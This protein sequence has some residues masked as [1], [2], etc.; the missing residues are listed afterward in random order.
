MTYRRHNATV[1]SQLRK[2][3]M[4]EFERRLY[5]HWGVYIGNQDIVHLTG[6]GD[7]ISGQF[8]S[9]HV[10]TISG[11]RFNKA[12]AVKDNFWAVA[13]DSIATQNN[14]LDRTR[15]PYSPN[16]IAKRASSMLG[17]IGYNALWHNC[18]H[19]ATYCRYGKKMSKQALV[20]LTG[21]AVAVV[22]FI[23]FTFLQ[24]NTTKY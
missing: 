11:K 2:G 4:V 18:E 24:G 9:K 23:W 3:D 12:R 22:L 17:E 20:V 6:E 10:F 7:G 15:T 1:L 13:A 8:A 14:Y 16:K 21:L 5:S 19:F